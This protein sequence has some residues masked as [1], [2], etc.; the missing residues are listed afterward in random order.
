MQVLNEHV[1]IVAGIDS[2]Q[3]YYN[4]VWRYNIATSVWSVLN[5]IPSNPRKGGVSFNNNHS[6]YYSTGIDLNNTRLRETWKLSNVVGLAE[7]K[8][9]NGYTLYPNP[10]EEMIYIENSEYSSSNPASYNI[11]DIRGKLMLKDRNIKKIKG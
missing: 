8:A 3:T 2:L 6:L 1:Y 7:I 9:S 4:D 5:S 10:A 11:Y